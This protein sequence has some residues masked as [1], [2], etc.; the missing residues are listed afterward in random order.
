MPFWS[1]SP[2]L[3]IFGQF[4]SSGQWARLVLDLFGQ[5]AKFGNFSHLVSGLGGKARLG[6]LVKN[7]Q[8]WRFL[9]SLVSGQGKADGLLVKTSGTGLRDR[10]SR[11]LKSRD[12]RRVRVGTSGGACGRRRL[13]KRR[14]Q[15]RFWNRRHLKFLNIFKIFKNFGKFAKG[16]ICQER[17]SQTTYTF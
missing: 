5:I 8:I 2:N 3:V 17:Q 14:A 12:F 6:L 16:K 9:V 10:K 7:R 1:K 11:L 4:K 15:R 13:I